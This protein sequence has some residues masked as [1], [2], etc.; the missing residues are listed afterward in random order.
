LAYTSKIKS[1]TIDLLLP[2][3]ERWQEVIKS[4]RISARSFINKNYKSY[5]SLIAPY[6]STMYKL[7]G[8]LY[9]D[10]MKSYSE[11]LQIP[12]RKIILM[13]CLYSLWLL[14]E[15]LYL[16]KREIIRWPKIFGC[17]AG[18][19]WIKGLGNTHL[20]NMDYDAE[21]LGNATRIFEFKQGKRKFI[22]VGVLG[23]AGVLSGMLPKKYAVTIN[24]APTIEKPIFSGYE[25][26]MLLREV[27]ESCDSYEEAVAE[28]KNTRLSTNV[29]YVVSGSKKGQACVIERTKRTSTVRKIKDN[30][31]AQ[32]NHFNSTKNKKH[33]AYLKCWSG[34]EWETDSLERQSGLE[35]EIEMLKG[36]ASLSRLGECLDS[37]DVISSDTYQQMIFLTTK[38]E[39]KAWRKVS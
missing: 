15:Y 17:T 18:I 24:Y 16:K 7:Y 10:E 26:L 9:V 22:T 29:F 5:Y 31:L 1:Y 27:F 20:R 33:N 36:Q 37:E 12:L 38:G 4:E 23:M 28:L 19:S 6:F 2:E 39:Y 13:N 25:P 34:K 14:G 3:E 35:K 21:G 30:V 11:A 8:G 32:A